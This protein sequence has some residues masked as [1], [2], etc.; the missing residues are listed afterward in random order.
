MHGKKKKNM[1][2]VMGALSAQ[3]LQGMSLSMNVDPLERLQ[4]KSAGRSQGRSLAG[5]K[6]K[7]K[8][9]ILGMV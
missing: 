7:E 6:K 9:S 2:G 5:I 8:K 3:P 4:Q 1:A